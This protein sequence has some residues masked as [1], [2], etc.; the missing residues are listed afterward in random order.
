MIKKPGKNPDDI[1][2]YRPVSLLSILSKILEKILLKR[3]PP[4]IDESKLIPSYQFG[5]RKKHGI[6]EQAHRLVNKINND[7]ESKRYKLC[8]F[9]RRKSSSR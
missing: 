7:L 8:G 4:I 2:L 3:L 1:T 5:F 6:I 9:H